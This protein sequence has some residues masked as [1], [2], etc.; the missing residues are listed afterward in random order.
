MIE[1]R[2]HP[3]TLIISTVFEP[4]RALILSYVDRSAPVEHEEHCCRNITTVE[5]RTSLHWLFHVSRPE[6]LMPAMLLNLAFCVLQ[7]SFCSRWN[8]LCM[9]STELCQTHTHA[10]A[11]AHTHTHTQRCT[12]GKLAC[13]PILECKTLLTY[14]Y[15]CVCAC[16]G[17]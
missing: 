13:K 10:R 1:T 2:E 11:T 4:S 12:V 3:F 14:I 15:V 16:M 17:V 6:L 8:R 9:V 7:Q 5:L